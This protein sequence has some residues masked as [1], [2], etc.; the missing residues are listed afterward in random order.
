MNQF[1]VSIDTLRRTCAGFAISAL[2]VACALDSD[3]V[4][5]DAD[6]VGDIGPEVGLDLWT[7]V[8]K[9]KPPYRAAALSLSH[10]V[11]EMVPDSTGDILLEASLR[12]RDHAAGAI[13]PQ[14][15]FGLAT[16]S[17][18]SILAQVFESGG[19]LRTRADLSMSDVLEVGAW[20]RVVVT[21][22]DAPS[23]PVQVRILD[24]DDVEVWR[25]C[26]AGRCPSVQ[27]AEA[28]LDSLRLSITVDDLREG[29]GQIELKNIS[30]KRHP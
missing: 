30:L 7:G 10:R 20:Y 29:L 18:E 6:S 3:D 24:S 28:E 22:G 21:I 17:S 2:L 11:L 26:D 4:G 1:K 14:V 23:R 15:S 5:S 9:P 19:Q 27:V 13:E 25:S 12:W 8:K 16:D